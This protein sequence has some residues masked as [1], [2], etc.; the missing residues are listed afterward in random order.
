MDTLLKIVGVLAAL[1]VILLIFAQDV[2]ATV[3]WYKSLYRYHTASSEL[4]PETKTLSQAVTITSTAT[5]TLPEITI[6]VPF[7]PQSMTDNNTIARS[8]TFAIRAN[9]TP[10]LREELTADKAKRDIICS[11]LTKLSYITDP[12]ASNY[13]FYAA[14]LHFKPKSVHFFSSRTIKKAGTLLLPY[15]SA[16]AADTMYAFTTPTIRGFVL[17]RDTERNFAVTFFTKN[18]TQI[19]LLTANIDEDSLHAVLAGI[20]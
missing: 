20:K 9:P 18:D 2:V 17:K 6:P 15:K 1:S 19:G 13:N 14:M 4:V 16:M 8:D 12:C 5:L 11:A 3:V 10:A 7:V